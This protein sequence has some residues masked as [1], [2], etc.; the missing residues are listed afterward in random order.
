[1]NSIKS[2][3]LLI[4][5]FCVSML[6]AVDNNTYIKQQVAYKDQVAWMSTTAKRVGTILLYVAQ[7][8]WTRWRRRIIWHANHETYG[9]D[10]YMDNND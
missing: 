9:T 1:M 8:Q 10:Y 4:T 2:I 6:Y 3:T 5:T 7:R